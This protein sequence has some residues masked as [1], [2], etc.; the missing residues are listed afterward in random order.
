MRARG[1]LYPAVKRREESR[2]DFKDTG[3]CGGRPYCVAQNYLISLDCGNATRLAVLPPQQRSGGWR[4]P[5]RPGVGV[6]CFPP[7]GM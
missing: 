4:P 2:K 6:E 1:R 7:P 5:A 3:L